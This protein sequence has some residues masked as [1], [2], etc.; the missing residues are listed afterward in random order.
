MKSRIVSVVP[1]SVTLVEMRD[2]APIEV[3]TVPGEARDSEARPHKPA[4]SMDFLCSRSAF[5]SW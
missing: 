4:A 1:A 2:F 5:D 3:H